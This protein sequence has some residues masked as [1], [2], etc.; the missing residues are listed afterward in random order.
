MAS[1]R[2]DINDTRCKACG[3][4][5]PCPCDAEKTI[6]G[7]DRKDKEVGQ[8]IIIINKRRQSR[9]RRHSYP[10]QRRQE[11]KGDGVIHPFSTFRWY[12]DILLISFISMHVILLPVSISFLSDDLS[13]HWLILNGIS[14]SIF[15]VDIVL[16]FK[17]GIVDPNNQDEVILDKKIIT[18]TY[19]RGWF[20]IDLISSLPFD[21]A[22]F[23]ASSS[24]AQQ[25]LIKASRALRILK[26]AKLLSLLR[27]LRVSRLVRYIKRF[28]ELL[29]IASGQLRIGKLIGC[30]LLLSHWNGCVQFLVPY[31]LEFPDNSWVVINGLQDKSPGTQYSW[32]LFNAMSHM[33]CIGYGRYPPQTITEVWLTLCSMTIGATFYAVFIGIMS[34]LIMSIDSSGR[35]YNEKLSQVKEYMRYRKLPFRIRLKV[36]EYYEHRFHHKLFDED[37]ILNELSK[38]LREE[39]LVHN[40]SPLL[41]A[42]PFFSNASRQFIADIVGKLKFEVYLTGEYICRTG[43]KGDKMYFIQRGIVD[44]LTKNGI[45]A[46]SLG[47]G[48]H[49][50]EICLLTKEARRVASIRAATICN[51]YSLC[52]PH[53]HEV[54]SEYPDMKMMLEEV[55][56]ERLSRIGLQPSLTEPLAEDGMTERT[57]FKLDEDLTTKPPP[58]SLSPIKQEPSTSTKTSTAPQP[59]KTSAAPQATKSSP[60]PQNTKNTKSS[61]AAPQA[62]KSS[63]TPQDTTFTPPSRSKSPRVSSPLPKGKEKTSPFLTRAFF[64]TVAP[65][66]ASFA[67]TQ[68]SEL[69]VVVE[70]D[71]E[72]IE[73]DPDVIAMVADF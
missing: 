43:R 45:L 53:F 52:S 33:L 29:N 55:A 66:L 30:M 4:F 42:V 36:D 21:Y 65:G 70:E 72:E 14:D 58:R 9:M 69:D 1:N 35:Q 12:W 5:Q 68:K 24:S 39:I 26:L 59:T 23:I 17:T 62:V 60:A 19:L 3:L 34:S 46:T 61:S 11:Q 64:N 6:H 50:G 22:Y 27:L 25:T 47:D 49:F 48:S 20:V 16:N 63:A 13:L 10:C 15:I 67:Q 37:V 18:R 32:A 2:K 41:H 38:A 28:E 51:L 31:L 44:V 71:V 40:V 56:K 8:P 7:F 57:A 73:E 54:L